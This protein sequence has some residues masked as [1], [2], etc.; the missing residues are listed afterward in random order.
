MMAKESVAAPA[1][2]DS[3]TVDETAARDMIA[4]KKDITPVPCLNASQINEHQP[5]DALG[6]EIVASSQNTAVVDPS[7]V[8]SSEM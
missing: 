6:F 3:P 2:H 5:D 8:A 1:S 7:P 4:M